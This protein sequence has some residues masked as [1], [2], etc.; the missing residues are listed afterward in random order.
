MKYFIDRDKSIIFLSLF[1]E[2]NKKLELFFQN[3]KDIEIATDIDNLD[4]KTYRLYYIE[5]NQKYLILD[6]FISNINENGLSEP[7]KFNNCVQ[8]MNNLL[9][10]IKIKSQYNS[11]CPDHI[12]NNFS[13]IEINK[14]P[15]IISYY[16]KEEIEFNF[17]HL[18]MVIAGISRFIN[19]DILKNSL[20]SVNVDNVFFEKYKL[21][22]ISNNV[23]KSNS[24][25]K[26]YYINLDYRDDRKKHIM[27]VLNNIDIPNER[28]SAI[29]PSRQDLVD[30]N[31]KYVGYYNRGI[32]RIR[33]YLDKKNTLGRGMGAF[34]CY[35]SHYFLL[36]RIRNNHMCE[37]ILIVEDDAQFNNEL[38]DR[39]EKIIKNSFHDKN[40]DWDILRVVWGEPYNKKNSMIKISDELFSYKNCNSQSKF[41][42][43]DN[44][45]NFHNGTTFQIINGRNINKMI[46]YL[47]SDFIYNIDAHYCTNKIKAY[48]LKY[49]NEISGNFTSDIRD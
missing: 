34:G 37:N 25:T 10:S 32:E 8:V 45:N 46:K 35:L 28:F 14:V 29:R 39:C 5:I 22:N 43:K 20:V 24:I 4:I 9:N 38:I 36:H 17:K 19:L 18:E 26:I 3:K 13:V 31:G 15:K 6:Q 48:V 33:K 47:N 41:A 21:R 40:V 42:K 2:Y 11:I 12:T 30:P 23:H 44:K 7:L 1:E 16:Y 49:D 27:S